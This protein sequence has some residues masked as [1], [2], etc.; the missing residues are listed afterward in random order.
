MIH[1]GHGSAN[2]TASSNLALATIL[3]DGFDCLPAA[4][5]HFDWH[6]DNALKHGL[7]KRPRQTCPQP[8][9]PLPGTSRFRKPPSPSQ[10]LSKPRGSAPA[11]PL[12]AQLLTRMNLQDDGDN[13]EFLRSTPSRAHPNPVT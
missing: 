6:R 10:S 11:A 12:N 2:Y 4:T 1:T 7:A 8:G 3:T 5:D 13:Q 9:K